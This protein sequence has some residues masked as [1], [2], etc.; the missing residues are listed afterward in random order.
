M[1]FF[2]ASA[3][4]VSLIMGFYLGFRLLY[5]F[6]ACQ[7]GYLNS[8][9]KKIFWF[10]ILSSA[11]SFIATRSL[12]A[13]SDFY[14]PLI[15][16]YL[17]SLVICA[18]YAMIFV[19]ILLLVRRLLLKQYRHYGLKTQM[20]FIVLTLT[21]F[22]VGIFCNKVPQTKYYQLT[23]NK[24]ANVKSLRIVQIS[25]IHIDTMTSKSTIEKLVQRVNHLKPD[26]LFITGDT[27]DSILQP[28]LDK[29]LAD[30]FSQIK[31]QYGV[32][33]ILGNH[34]HYGIQRGGESN[35]I[36]SVVEAFQAS[37][38]NVL[39]DDAI[40]DSKTGISLIGRNDFV[41]SNFNQYRATLQNLMTDVDTTKPV[42]LLDHQ[43]R[44]LQ[45]PE[46]QGV[47]LMFSG[48]THAGQ[49]FP[50]T[51]V[52]NAM[53]INPW[54]IYQSGEFTSIVTSGYGLWGPPIRL[55]TRAEIVVADITF[56]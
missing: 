23:I 55:M 19:D 39:N 49:V 31:T 10:I 35:T 42:I 2:L 12:S 40:Y 29:Q 13:I 5:L 28:Y 9:S 27:L 38:M 18:F 26:Y 1:S 34:E 50:M 53:F 47:D 6:N 7:T 52:I 21:L 51:L 17:F 45:L 30:I 43:P 16:N 22:A 33:V 25:D 3:V 8:R 32:W 37:N 54:G 4:T 44:N 14:L 36:N 24:S 46:Q 56:N 15:G 41:V 48:H 11:L 20:G